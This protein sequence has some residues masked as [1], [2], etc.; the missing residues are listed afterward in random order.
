MSTES[1]FEYVIVGSGAGGG[2]LAARLVEFGHRVLLLEAGND[3][4]ASQS[5]GDGSGPS[6]RVRADYQVPVFHAFASENE[7]LKWDFFVRH[8]SSEE[9]QQK[10]P[11]Y[12]VTADK[13]GLPRNGVLYPRASTLGG[14]T[15]HHAQIMVYPHNEDWEYIARLT[16][17]SS[18][19]AE[20]M[21]S[22]FERIERCAYR[23]RKRLLACLGWNPTRHG[24]HGW[25]QTEV[26]M[27]IEA[28][29][30]DKDLLKT[31]AESMEQ[32]FWAN[33]EFV[34]RL[35]WGAVG[36]GDPNDWRL[37]QENALGI[38]YVPISTKGHARHAVRE[39]VLD[40][41]RK[42][43]DRLRI[44]LDALATKILFDQDN[45]A[46]GVEY[47]K[48]AR[49]Y[50]A[51]PNAGDPQPEQREQVLASREV[52]LAGGAFNTP[53]LLQLSG[54]GPRAELERLGIA[55][56]V[57]LPGVGST[58]QDRYE[59]SVVNRM[60]DEW[61]ALKGAT[62]STQDRQ[63]KQWLDQRSG[64][65]TTNGAILAVTKR[66]LPDRPL[67][68]L[69]LFALLGRFS[70]YFPGYSNDLSEHL[71]YLTWAIIKGH[72]NNTAGTVRLRT[73]DPR[74]VPEI[75]FRYF[76]EGSDDN[77]DDLQS[78]VEGIKFVRQ[79]TKPLIE[80][81]VIAAE[82]LPGESV[83]SDEDLA[84]FIQNHAWGHH[85]SCSCPIG[86]QIHGG[87]VNGDFSV[88]GTKGLRIVD[89]SVFPRIP[90]F[91][92]V[93]SVYMIAEKAADVISRDAK[94]AQR[95]T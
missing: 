42:H 6:S 39:R 34:Q 11:K 90:G 22:Y 62:F 23:K 7:E 80:S 3:P 73:T 67:P 4:I 40:V 26:A 18:W 5:E 47:L 35:K 43:P 91:F 54:I 68:D 84:E 56:R 57:D 45:R 71:N 61:E 13:D 25:L 79:L 66:S 60:R 70:G 28:L 14:C 94:A 12:K 21:R 51:H 52:I 85:A 38:H 59:I 58:L 74:D 27:P 93:T 82:E 41:A 24:F 76:S 50:R 37:V 49:L 8:Y 36:Q 69:F 32:A 33:D 92:L 86:D 44:E 20:H 83:Q 89:A 53:Q 95:T 31:M 64:V 19:S 10:D 16:G 15:A 81:G 9:K 88:H 75:N 48:G 87:V 17:D 78:V 2:T 1:P 55:V 29:A 77:G 65:Y 63:Y 46:I 72:T 30:E